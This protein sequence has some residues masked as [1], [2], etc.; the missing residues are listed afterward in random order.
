MGTVHGILQLKE[1]VGGQVGCRDADVLGD[2]TSQR[3]DKVLSHRPGGRFVCYGEDVSIIRHESE[4][5]TC[6]FPSGVRC[7]FV[8]VDPHTLGTIAPP[9]SS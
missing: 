9:H 7:S 5:K 3:A 6:S 2:Y 4:S 8:W 1:A